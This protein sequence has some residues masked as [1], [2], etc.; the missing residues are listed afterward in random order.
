MVNMKVLISDIIRKIASSIELDITPT[1][2]ELEDKKKERMR[3]ES[4]QTNNS[5]TKNSGNGDEVE[6]GGIKPTARPKVKPPRR[7]PSYKPS[8]WDSKQHRKEY[9]QGWR[10][11]G[12]DV[13]TGNKYMKKNKSK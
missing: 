11:E 13:E 5:S 10:S 12:K 4:P 1:D 3:S 2:K 9:M 8:D 6:H 7:N